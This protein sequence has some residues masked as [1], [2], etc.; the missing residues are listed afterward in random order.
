MTPGDSAIAGDYV[1]TFTASCSETSADAEF[2]VSVKTQTIWGI[3]AVLIILAL[4]AG[5]AAVFKKYGRR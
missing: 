3:V 2:R 1:C 4:I 5:V